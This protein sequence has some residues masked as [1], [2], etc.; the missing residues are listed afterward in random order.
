MQQFRGTR[1]SH[2]QCHSSLY[3]LLNALRTLGPHGAPASKR[4][5]LLLV[6]SSSKPRA[7]MRHCC[8][9]HALG[10]G[11]HARRPAHD[12]PLRSSGVMPLMEQHARTA[13]MTLVSACPRLVYRSTAFL[14]ITGIQLIA[15]GRRNWKMAP[16]LGDLVHTCRLLDFSRHV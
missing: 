1:Q 14:A 9:A 2:K 3:H 15:A 7:T 4:S 13:A 6:H 11:L 5:I 16:K 12:Q 8:Q 10:V